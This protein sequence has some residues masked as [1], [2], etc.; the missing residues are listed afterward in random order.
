MKRFLSAALWVIGCGNNGNNP[1]PDMATSLSQLALPGDTFYPE[2]LNAAA[3]GTLFVGS[4]GTGAV[5]KV[6]P[7]SSSVV[8]FLAGGNPKGV[9]GVL[10]DSASSTLY[11]CAVDL[12][13]MVPTSEVRAYD[14]VSA[15]LKATYPFPNAAFCNDLALET[16]HGR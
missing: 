9:T 5:V 15:A 10:P 3:D 1:S 4:L 7:G 16:G 14:L 12:S 6:A 11:L 13:T 8:Q 2:S